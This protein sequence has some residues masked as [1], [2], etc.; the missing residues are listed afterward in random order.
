MQINEV[1]KEVDLS[2][3]AIKYYEEEGLLVISKDKNGYRNYTEDNIKVL[4]EISVYRKLGIS[5]KDIKILL[6]EKN[7]EILENIY[8]EKSSNLEKYEAEV[9]ALRNFIDNNELEEIYEV[10]NYE[11]VAKAIENA[12]PK[13]YGYFFLNHFMP[14]LQISIETEEQKKAYNNIIEFLDNTKLK[15][16]IA[17]KLVGFINFKLNKAIIGDMAEKVDKQMKRFENITEEDYIKLREQTRK[18][19]KLKESLFY[20]YNPIFISQRKFM[21]NLQD[22]GYNDIFIPNMILLSPQYR[23]YHESLMQINKRIC[24]DLGL[25][26]DSKYN[27][28]MKK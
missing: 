20:K 12:V 21:R 25:Y 28:I 6:K 8:K 2:K 10:L 13:F 4:K 22:C 11:T 7:K 3:R 9:K 5:I 17:M 24:D 1:V 27:L 19:V 26:Y 18:N 15:I 23:R 16:P 14:Y